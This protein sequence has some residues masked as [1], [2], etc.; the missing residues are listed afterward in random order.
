MTL[1][2][3]RL[4]YSEE[5][6][7][8]AN[9]Q[10]EALVN[11]FARV[12]REEFLGAGPWSIPSP[13]ILPGA[14]PSYRA[15]PDADARRLYHN[16]PIAIDAVRALNNGQPSALASWIDSLAP[17]PG[18]H[19]LHVGCGVGYYTAI[20]AELAG[21]GGRVTAIETDPEL[22]ARAKRNLQNWK[23]VEVLHG[24]GVVCDF[25]SFDAAL[26]N[27]GVTTLPLNWLNRMNSNGRLLVPL[28]F[29]AES[30]VLGTGFTLLVK[31]DETGF[32]ARFTS[33]VGIFSCTGARD[34][35][36]N[37]RIR[38]MLMN[39]RWRAIKQLRRDP[40]EPDASCV[41]HENDYCISAN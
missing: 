7:T 37:T 25:E 39:G 19:V 40:H 15:T 22:A 4:F 28:T 12:R 16:V 10:N 8:V 13:E 36:A 2:D 3:Y 35:G 5:I 41:L 26:I 27:A 11:A 17:R 21:A 24:D 34:A 14:K 1:D 18:E 38:E 32:S 29:A 23:Q 9:I 6:R 30:Q 20:L 33:G 31:R